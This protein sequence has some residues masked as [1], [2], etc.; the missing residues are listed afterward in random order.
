MT[1]FRPVTVSTW[2]KLFLFCLGLA[3]ASAF[4]MKWMEGDLTI[5][6]RIVHDYP[7]TILG[8]EIFYSKQRV[9]DIFDMI[10]YDVLKILQY[11]LSF[12]FV[13]M[14]GVY[15]GITALCMIARERTGAITMKKAL[16]VMGALQIVAWIADVAENGFLFY[17]LS[18]TRWN[19]MYELKDAVSL[20]QVVTDTQFAIYH[21]V[22][23]IK[24]V[25]ALAGLFFALAF[26]LRKR[27][28]GF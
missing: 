19:R 10:G 24:W 4:C 17:W 23:I 26:V 25:I 16:F 22:V 3:I 12:D 9:T 27:K 28:P 6:G 18:H 20:S 2:K 7:F 8:L 13:F 14:A 5:D 15:P 11:H 21:G 1:L